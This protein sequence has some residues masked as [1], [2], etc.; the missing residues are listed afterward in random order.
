MMETQSGPNELDE[1]RRIRLDGTV[2]FRDL[3]G[4]ETVDGRC[5][6][7][8]QVFR[9][10]SLARLSVRDLEQ[11]QVMG[12]KLVCDLRAPAEV[13]KAPDRLPEH[14]VEYLQL[15]VVSSDFD[16]VTAMERLKQKDTS[17]LTPTFMIDAYRNN[18]EFYGRTW[19]TIVTRLAEADSRPL[20][21]HCTA[22]KD[23]TG[24]CAALILSVLGVPEE[25]IIADHAVSN[26]YFAETV[27]KINE[28]IRSLGVD[29]QLV[30]P[31][32]SAPRE[33]MVFVL[34]HIRK[35]YGSAAMYLQEKGAVVPEVIASLRETMLVGP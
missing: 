24:V 13:H 18:I 12:L 7:W 16:T 33:A 28:Y 25:T 14:G 29:P 27:V 31:Y 17:W 20:L 21:F 32:L 11:L 10:D 6:K 1:K 3:G 26:H 22:G 2:N 34:E 19:G 35:T 9:S 8:G 4:Y 5:T 15:P 23:R 30:A